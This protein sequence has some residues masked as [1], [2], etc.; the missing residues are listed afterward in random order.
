MLGIRGTLLG[1]CW[2][3]PIHCAL[4]VLL[5]HLQG[6]A[7]LL[8]KVSKPLL[9]FIVF[10]NIWRVSELRVVVGCIFVEAA[11]S[12]VYIG[13]VS[14]LAHSERRMADSWHVCFF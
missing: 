8:L 2:W 13:P 3:L 10:F 14:R 11:L 1:D 6:H 5:D 4:L 12:D 9:L 7:V